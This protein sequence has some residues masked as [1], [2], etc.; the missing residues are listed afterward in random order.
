M[1]LSYGKSDVEFGINRVRQ[2]TPYGRNFAPGC[3]GGRVYCFQTLIL[4]ERLWI[5]KEKCLKSQNIEQ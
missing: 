1:N 4:F 3:I 2:F 5:Q